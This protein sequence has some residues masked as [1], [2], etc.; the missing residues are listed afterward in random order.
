M[1]SD[2][3][4]TTPSPLYDL[5]LLQRKEKSW[6]PESFDLTTKLLHVNPE[7]YTVWNYRRNILLNGLFP[8]RYSLLSHQVI[9]PL[10]VRQSCL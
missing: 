1:S 9:P 7:F 2:R 4:G 3:A 10:I 5:P 8:T 6:T